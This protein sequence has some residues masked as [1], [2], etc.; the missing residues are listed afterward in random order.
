[1]ENYGFNSALYS[2]VVLAIIAVTLVFLKDIRTEKEDDIDTNFIKVLLHRS[3][4]TY[5]YFVL[6]YGD[7]WGYFCHAPAFC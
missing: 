2:T 3:V 6:W 5:H 1:M 7:F 4:L